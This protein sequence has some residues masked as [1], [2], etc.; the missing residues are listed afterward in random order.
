MLQRG[1]TDKMRLSRALREHRPDPLVRWCISET[2][3][4]F[5]LVSENLCRKRS[6]VRRALV[7]ARTLTHLFHPSSCCPCQGGL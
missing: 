1:R 2:A 4:E 6:E 5:F 3:R 7:A